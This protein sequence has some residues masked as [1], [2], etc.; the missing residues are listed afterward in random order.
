MK[1]SEAKK[2]FFEYQAMNSKKNHHA[3]LRASDRPF[4]QCDRRQ[5]N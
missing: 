2:L 4:L 5:G 3:Q 1:L